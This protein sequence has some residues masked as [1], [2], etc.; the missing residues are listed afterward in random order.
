MLPCLNGDQQIRNL[1]DDSMRP[2]IREFVREILRCQM[3]E[4]NSELIEF[5][6]VPHAPCGVRHAIRRSA[7]FD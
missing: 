3:L 1:L 2:E 6:T 4:N 7:L 5:H